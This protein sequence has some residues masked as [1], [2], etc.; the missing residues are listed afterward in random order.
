METMASKWPGRCKR[1]GV[2]FPT[3]TPIVW[4]KETGA[5]HVT[6]DACSEAIIH[7]WFHPRHL[8]MRL[9]DALAS[10]FGD[11]AWRLDWETDRPDEDEDYQPND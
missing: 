2:S 6:D 11:L 8:L 7:P 3:G 5:T 9:C 10:F 1:C 4:S